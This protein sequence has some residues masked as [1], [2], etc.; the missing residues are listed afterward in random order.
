TP[1]VIDDPLCPELHKTRFRERQRARDYDPRT[2]PDPACMAHADFH[3]DAFVPNY[4][5]TEGTRIF[6]S[7]AD[8]PESYREALRGR[9]SEYLEK[10]RKESPEAADNMAKGE[11]YSMEP[12]SPCV[13]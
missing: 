2:E 9:W 4:V 8:A 12:H 11:P 6:M 3:E 1:F 13:V 5:P 7:W 10:V